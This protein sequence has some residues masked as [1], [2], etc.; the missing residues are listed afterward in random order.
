MYILPSI[1]NKHTYSQEKH[2]SADSLLNDVIAHSVPLKG[3]TSNT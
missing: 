3:N 2:N 1:Y